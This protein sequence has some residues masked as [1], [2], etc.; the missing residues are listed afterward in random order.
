LEEE[1]MA[2]NHRS[3]EKTW[4]KWKEQEEKQLRELDVD[5]DTI[6]RLHTY[7]W[8]QFK[9][10][11]NFYEKLS[12][13]SQVIEWTPQMNDR[14]LENADN[15]LNNIENKELLAILEKVD[16]LTLEMLAMRIAGYSTPQ[17]CRR[18]HVTRYSYY[19]RIKRLKE[20]LKNFLGSD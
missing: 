7:D 14:E 18:F 11:R 3:A 16:K 15:L 12:E 10:D 5:E 6:Q 20:K 19:N 13:N 9:A 2:Y 4:A 1:A 17:I 8:Q